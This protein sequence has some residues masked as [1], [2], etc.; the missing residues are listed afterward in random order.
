MSKQPGTYFCWKCKRRHRRSSKI[1]RAHYRTKAYKGARKKNPAP[2]GAPD[3]PMASE[4]VN[5]TMNT[6]QLY[7]NR[8][9]PFVKNYARK[10]VRG[11]F[12]RD[13]AIKGLANNLT[14]DA[15]NSYY[16]EYMRGQ[17][18]P[19]LDAAT[20]W[21]YGR[22]LLNWI[23]D[24]IDWEVREMKGKKNPCGSRRKRKS[25][26][27]KRRNQPAGRKPPHGIPKTRKFDGKN[28]TYHLHYFKKSHT[29]DAA[30]GARRAGFKYRVVKMKRKVNGRKRTLY[31]LY[32]RR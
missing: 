9:R 12:N 6:A 27:R 11:T 2:K 30:R 13:L 15:Q 3:E 29:Q 5:H 1:G 16:R 26:K 17:R 7:E 21:E 23:M 24:E 25:N 32:R 20:K 22:Q 31:A 8:V 10:K 4:L 14:K 18:A 19:Q 28:Y